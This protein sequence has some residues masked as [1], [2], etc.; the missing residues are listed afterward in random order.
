MWRQRHPRRVD[1]PPRG[2]PDGDTKDHLRA[3]SAASESQATAAVVHRR[4]VF[5]MPRMAIALVI[6]VLVCVALSAHSAF[7]SQFI[8]R[9]CHR[10]SAPSGPHVSAVSDSLDSRPF[11]MAA[12]SSGSGSTTE[13]HDRRASVDRST[14]DASRLHVR[15][16]VL[17][18]DRAASLSRCLR[19]LR[20]ADYGGDDVSLDIHVDH[21]F[22][23]VQL[24]DPLQLT[25]RL[26]S[27]AWGAGEQADDP[28]QT[29]SAAE[30]DLGE[31]SAQIRGLEANPQ[32]P[33]GAKRGFA[34]PSA[35]GLGRSAF[36][37][38]EAGDLSNWRHR[39]R[40]WAQ[41]ARGQGQGQ[42]R[43]GEVR[44]VV[45]A[46]QR[47]GAGEVASKRR[48]FRSVVAVADSFTWQ[49]G[50]KQVHVRSMNGG[51][52]AQWMEAWWPSGANEFAFVLEDDVA[53]SPFFYA[54]LKRM[55]HRYYYNNTEY[56]SNVY[57]ISLQRQRL[58]PGQ[59]APPIAHTGRPFLYSLVGTWGQL[60]LPAP[61]RAFRV[62]YD[63]RRYTPGRE[64]VIRGLKTTGFWKGRVCATG[65]RRM[66]PACLALHYLL[67]ACLATPAPLSPSPRTPPCSPLHTALAP[68]LAAALTRLVCPSQQG[69]SIWT[70]WIV[71]WAHATAALN[72][73]ASLPAGLALS[74]SHREQGESFKQSKGADATLL[75]P[76]HLTA[77]ADISAVEQV[78][79]AEH[80]NAREHMME[81]LSAAEQV[82]AAEQGPW[83]WEQLP[84]LASLPRFDFCLRP[85][86]WVGRG[87]TA[88]V[89]Q[90]GDRGEQGEQQGAGEHRDAGQRSGGGREAEAAA[91]GGAE[92]GG[93]GVD[94]ASEGGDA[95][96]AG[97]AG[98][99]DA[100][101][102]SMVTRDEELL[103][104]VQSARGVT[105][106][107]LLL[108]PDHQPSESPQQQHHAH[109]HPWASALLRAT[110]TPAPP[111]WQQLARNWA[112]HVDGLGV[113]HYAV[114]TSCPALA[115]HLATR[116]HL[117][118][119]LPSSPSPPSSDSPSSPSTPLIPSP[120]HL[121][122]AVQL[123]TRLRVP[124]LLASPAV[125]WGG[126]PFLCLAPRLLHPHHSH[127]GQQGE[128][129]GQWQWGGSSPHEQGAKG[130]EQATGQ[131]PQGEGQYWERAGVAVGV[132]D[133]P[134]SDVF[135]LPPSSAAHS[136]LH[137]LLA[138]LLWGTPTT[139]SDG[140]SS[141]VGSNAGDSNGQGESRS[142]EAL[143][144]AWLGA[145]NSE[146]RWAALEE[147]ARKLRVGVTV[148]RVGLPCYMAPSEVNSSFESQG[149]QQGAW[150]VAG[151]RGGTAEE[152]VVGMKGAGLW[153]LDSVDYVSAVMPAAV[154]PAAATACRLAPETRTLSD[155][156]FETRAFSLC[157]DGAAVRYR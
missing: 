42:R 112:C 130:E 39:G 18:F 87:G 141:D 155:F 32:L 121:H 95:E 88:W 58:V 12:D 91:I 146:A 135:L 134:L 111:A 94:D 82:G 66:G 72:L 137:S 78:N 70:P 96:S 30:G 154:M 126:D 104:A 101:Y 117:V 77:T 128:Q 33:G 156:A 81:H 24:N 49:H 145:G 119:L 34:S 138:H 85:L 109:A 74:V 84:P 67:W 114:L 16:I 152:A 26:D 103:R 57:G 157:C 75:M 97:A 68:V 89:W 23:G 3:T 83:W 47:R 41:R 59:P 46:V 129:Q 54:Y 60:L 139:S 50:H 93:A 51:V 53:V 133:S 35:V 116:G 14:R 19:S 2:M 20:A 140:G 132:G 61:W 63:A 6:I 9:I 153:E 113:S 108:L 11:A 31:G 1:S 28:L 8:Q 25:D 48:K 38:E 37:V 45:G 69:N 56:D 102:A 110:D 43:L 21:P 44:P 100:T 80:L 98:V 151:G 148:W 17:T 7:S 115:L 120:A 125:T 144:A 127:A 147:A 52:Q 122:T 90:G 4:P 99:A 143:R 131:Q 86:P 27:R 92:E 22:A 149:V 106:F 10:L 73:Y 40:L 107:A 124:L 65:K 13:R 55:L 150:M 105:S 142:W 79:A 62:W 5:F 64:P 71:R 15:L 123:S 136:A 29:D 118:S 36:G 76:H